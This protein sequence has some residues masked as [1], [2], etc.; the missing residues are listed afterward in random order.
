M[1]RKSKGEIV[2]IECDKIAL[3]PWFDVLLDTYLAESSLN[4]KYFTNKIKSTSD[5]TKFIIEKRMFHYSMTGERVFVSFIP[6]D[7]KV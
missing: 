3:N 4:V 2:S 5:P 6:Y 7:N 1:N